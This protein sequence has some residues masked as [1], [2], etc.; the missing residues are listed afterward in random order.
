MVVGGGLGGGL[1]GGGGVM[2]PWFYD[3]IFDSQPHSSKCFIISV[4]SVLL[5]GLIFDL[6]S[7]R[8]FMSFTKFTSL[9]VYRITVYRS[10]AFRATVHESTS[11]RVYLSMNHEYTSKSSYLG[12]PLLPAV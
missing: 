6:S 8:G 10:R 12:V 11:P 7:V 2:N 1:V 9:R 5:E 4:L 3:M